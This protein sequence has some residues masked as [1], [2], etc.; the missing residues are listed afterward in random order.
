MLTVVRARPP[1]AQPPM[2]LCHV[3]RTSGE[4]GKV[5]KHIRTQAMGNY[6]NTSFFFNTENL[7]CSIEGDCGSVNK[8]GSL[9][10]FI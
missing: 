9:G 10:L 7:H 6:I 4:G 8:C 3:G 1:P 2:M 5:Q